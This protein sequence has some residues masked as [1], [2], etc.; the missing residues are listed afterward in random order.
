MAEATQ[1]AAQTNTDAGA[2]K[3]APA[4]AQTARVPEAAA[5]PD[6]AKGGTLLGKEKKAEES[7]SLL[8]DK[9]EPAAGDEKKEPEEKKPEGAPK[10][11]ADFALPE[12]AAVNP[13]SLA[14]Y[15]AT[16][17][18]L[19]LTQEA[20]QTLIDYETERL[21]AEQKAAAVAFAAQ[22]QKWRDELLQDPAHDQVIADAR[23]ALKR[24][25][26]PETANLITS[27]AWG[28]HPGLIR[29]LAKAG[30]LVAEPRLP[31]G[32]ASRGLNPSDRARIMYPSM[33]N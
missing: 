19:G 33:P 25:A 12:G 11:Y 18:E 17:K 22:R 20:A 31:E 29:L 30:K 10:E 9:V 2:G 14:S 28:D 3:T 24:L 26:D 1:A 6:P 4:A 32:T 8:A 13:E 7:T 23:T 27:G 16:A 15:K 21:A 5:Q